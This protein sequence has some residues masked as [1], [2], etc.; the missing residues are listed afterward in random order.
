MFV[1]EINDS[2]LG[3]K[4]V[5]RK[6]LGLVV[7]LE[8]ITSM[9]RGARYSLLGIYTFHRDPLNPPL[10]WLARREVNDG[11]SRLTAI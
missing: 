9:V 8:D 11:G 2:R 4:A 3:L 5:Y 7:C 1:V 10:K 6:R